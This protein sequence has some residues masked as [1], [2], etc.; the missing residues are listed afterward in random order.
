MG[1]IAKD[2]E[3]NDSWPLW[4]A[5][6]GKVSMTKKFKKSRQRVVAIAGV[7]MAAALLAA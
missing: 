1:M 5:V 4:I 6:G 3:S 2:A 7:A